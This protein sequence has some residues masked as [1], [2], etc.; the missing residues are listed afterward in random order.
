[1]GI[2]TQLFSYVSHPEH[3]SITHPVL[4]IGYESNEDERN[5]M[6]EKAV[7][8]QNVRQVISETC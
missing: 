5:F 3:Y 8:F 1:M 2:H 4:E 6:V 7:S